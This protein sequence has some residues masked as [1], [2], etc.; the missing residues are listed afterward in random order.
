M[1][2]NCLNPPCFPQLP[3]SSIISIFGNKEVVGNTDCSMNLLYLIDEQGL[4][5]Q[6]VTGSSAFLTTNNRTIQIGS[7]EEVKAHF[8]ACSRVYW[9]L[10]KFFSWEVGVLQRPPTI[11]LGYFDSTNETML[12]AIQAITACFNCYTVFTHVVYD[13]NG[14]AL[15]DTEQST[16]LAEFATVSEKKFAVLPTVDYAV[17]GNLLKVSEYEYSATALLNEVCVPVLDVNCVETPALENVYDIQ[18]LGLAA[19]L[20][21]ISSSS[22]DYSFT[23]KFT[24][25]NYA[26][27][28]LSTALLDLAQ[29]R[30]ITGVNP[31]SGG[32]NTLSKHYV[33]VYHSVDYIPMFLEG[34]TST[35][36]YID[37]IIHRIHIKNTLEYEIFKLLRENQSVSL[38]DLTKLQNTLSLTVRNLVDQKLITDEPNSIDKSKF[39]DIFLEGNGWV[40]IKSPTRAVNINSRISPTFRICYVRPGS[41]HFVS[42]G[43]CET[44]VKEI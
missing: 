3:I 16:D 36:T 37:Y 27:S 24:P 15:Y 14:N 19:V 2:I 39:K 43:L 38:S 7:V 11:T 9:E 33:N 34:L 28:E 6:T 4:V 8:S 42:I 29:T 35:G 17:T 20:T 21:S 22:I 13:K 18:H 44:Q 30:E 1:A 5:D 10:V 31:L 23:T 41:T 25:K 26:F 32:V 12:D 40:V